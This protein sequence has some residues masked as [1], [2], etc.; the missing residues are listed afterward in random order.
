MALIKYNVSRALRERAGLRID[1]IRELLIVNA[2]NEPNKNKVQINALS[3]LFYEILIKS[4][5]KKL[6]N[7]YIS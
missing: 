6:F 5:F 7:Y 3:V 1:A 2:T 4:D